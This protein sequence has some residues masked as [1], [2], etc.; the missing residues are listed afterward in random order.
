ML[1]QQTVTLRDIRSQIS[2][3]IAMVAFSRER[4]DVVI[5]RFGKPVATIIN[6]EDYERLMNPA[7]RFSDEKWEKGFR[8]MDKARAATKDIPQLEIDNTIT[9]AVT[10]VRKEK[11][12]KNMTK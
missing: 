4:Q 1:S 9:Q 8:L 6:Y 11:A 2:K 5:T 3:L 7:S 10:E 12:S